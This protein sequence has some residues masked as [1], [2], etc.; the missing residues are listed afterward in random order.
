MRIDSMP[1]AALLLSLAALAGCVQP[2]WMK[3]DW[4]KPEEKA[5]ADSNKRCSQAATTAA[6][7]TGAARRQAYSDCMARPGE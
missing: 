3:P 2:D 7:E 5:F 6:P 4:T 1:V